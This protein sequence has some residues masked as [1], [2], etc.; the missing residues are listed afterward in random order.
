MQEVLPFTASLVGSC[1]MSDPEQ[2]HRLQL[3][4]GYEDS[5]TE[6]TGI[7]HP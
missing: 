7:G 2:M 1:K 4:M 5:Y 3:E 6:A